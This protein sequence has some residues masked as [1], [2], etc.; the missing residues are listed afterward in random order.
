MSTGYAPSSAQGAPPEPLVRQVEEVIGEP[1]TEWRKPNTGLTAAHRFQ[2]QF[3]SGRKVF[4]KAATTPETAAMLRNERV[5]LEVVPEEFT[6]RVIAWLEGAASPVLVVED[7]SDGHWPASHAGVNWRSGDIERV[8]KAIRRLGNEQAPKGLPQ[9]A[10]GCE[11][12]WPQVLSAPEGF[13]ELRLCSAAWLASWGEALARAEGSL[14]QTGDALVH[15]DIRSDNICLTEERVVFVDWSNARAGAKEYDLALF[16]P[17][18]H[19]EGAPPPEQIWPEGG[20]W[21]AMQ[22]GSLA[23]RAIND[24]DAPDW[25]RRVFRRLAKINLVWAAA[26]LE[27][28]DPSA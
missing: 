3:A 20:Q 12:H 28:P 17:A 5:A 24:V 10:S 4:I 15:G 25:L 14:E 7:L 9:T 19:L 8:L 22:A 11:L 26:G 23:L 6:P 13:L 21:A 27:L 16:L 2:V 1:S 18:A